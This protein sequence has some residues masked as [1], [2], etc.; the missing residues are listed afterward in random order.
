MKNNKKTSFHENLP[1]YFR[2]NINQEIKTGEV[3]QNICRDLKNNPLYKDFFSKFDPD[4]I[5]DFIE[6]YSFRKAKY[7][8]YGTMI[9]RNEESSFLRSEVEADERIWEIQRKK[10]FDLECKWRA[11]LIKIP[12]I[13][14]TLDFEYWVKNIENCPFLEPIADE[15]IDIYI[16]YL[17]SDD[18]ID[19][20]L[21]YLW[22]GYREIKET[23]KEEGNPPP[24]YEYY[25]LHKGTGGL[26]YLP[27]IRGEKE[28][29]YT[30]IWNTFI[31]NRNKNNL[32]NL[33]T[34]K[35][36]LP[37]LHSYD[38][39]VVEEFIR[40][41]EDEK[42]LDY[43]LLYEKQL[44][45]FNNEIDHALNIL[46]DAN[47]EIPI[48]SHYNWK[49]AII[50][51]ARKY[52]QKSITEACKRAYNRYKSRINAGISQEQHESTS[53]IKWIREW[54]KNY[55]SRIIQARKFLGEPE[56]LNF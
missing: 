6:N 29:Y 22:M 11:E 46:K 33:I 34:V 47:E 54:S 40:K 48:E 16:N 23:L 49:A 3:I 44:N 56:D 17:L 51:A 28:E 38:L 7:L 13:E 45:F 41:Y 35:G 27:D 26:L 53:S 14:L 19:F 20:R 37:Y 50:L 52:E 42:L 24:W 55:R 25:D 18:F 21:E 1:N 31:R 9:S 12:E 39:S 8:H 15:E 36:S 30:N 32:K 4:S 5:D 2:E 43:F 10:L